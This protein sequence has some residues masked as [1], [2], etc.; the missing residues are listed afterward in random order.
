MSEERPLEHLSDDELDL[1][2]RVLEGYTSDLYRVIT[3]F[4]DSELDYDDTPIEGEMQTK[5]GL[6]KQ[7]KN[8]IARRH[9]NEEAVIE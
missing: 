4:E 8:E 3:I 1:L 7:V 6:V 2:D 5:K 9:D